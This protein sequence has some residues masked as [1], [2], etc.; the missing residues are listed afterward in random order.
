MELNGEQIINALECCYSSFIADCEQCPY[1]D[2]A[3]F[4]EDF[5]INCLNMLLKDALSLIKELE[6]KCASLNDENE[7]LRAEGE[8]KDRFG[9]KFANPNYHCS[10]CGKTALDIVRVTNLGKPYN[11]QCLSPYCPHCGAKMKGE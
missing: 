10:V 11:E 3:D 9:G 2:R 7:R 5:S 4:E 8:W 1:K 6:R